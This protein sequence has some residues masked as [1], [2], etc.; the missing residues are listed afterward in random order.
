MSLFFLQMRNE[1]HKLF[2]RKRTYLGFAAFVAV[3]IE[4]WIRFG[5]R[6]GELLA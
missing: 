3:E 5:A 4:K 6:R 2:A 1:L